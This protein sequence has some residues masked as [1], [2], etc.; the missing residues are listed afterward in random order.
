M[1]LL[2]RRVGV[3]ATQLTI[4]FSPHLEQLPPRRVQRAQHVSARFS[5]ALTSRH[6]QAKVFYDVIR[7]LAAYTLLRHCIF[8][9]TVI[10]KPI[11]GLLVICYFREDF[12]RIKA[13]NC[14]ETSNLRQWVFVHTS[15]F[16]LFV[17]L[18]FFFAFFSSALF[19]FFF[20]LLSMAKMLG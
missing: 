11:C 7:P 1:I 13:A 20:F 19:F 8:A 16:L 14:V 15:V 3:P 9:C 2:L 10:R 5:E 6:Q 17:F 12:V 4:S 18:S